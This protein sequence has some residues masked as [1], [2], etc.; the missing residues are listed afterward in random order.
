IVAL[1]VRLPGP[2]DRRALL[3][4]IVVVRLSAPPWFFDAHDLVRSDDDASTVFKLDHG[5]VGEDFQRQDSTLSLVS[6]HARANGW[7]VALERLIGVELV[8]K[9]ALQAT[10]TAGDLRRIERGFLKLGHA[11]GDRGH[12]R[13]VGVAADRLA[14]VAIIRQ[15]LGL[16]ADA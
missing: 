11:H 16:V 8:A 3:G 6:S 4:E 2:R 9:A 13:E 1:S 12:S 7:Q 15:Q 14:A 5:L 10:A